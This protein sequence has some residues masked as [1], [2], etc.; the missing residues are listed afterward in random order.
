MFDALVKIYER[1]F[2]ETLLVTQILV[3][4]AGAAISEK[5]ILPKIRKSRKLEE[6]K[7]IFISNF[8]EVFTTFPK[9]NF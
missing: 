1:T 8:A 6:N 2:S 3:F 5:N 9:N 4:L 7:N